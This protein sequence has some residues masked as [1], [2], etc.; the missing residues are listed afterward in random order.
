MVENEKR[1]VQRK[2]QR[3][4]LELSEIYAI[5]DE[6]MIAHIGFNDPDTN[7]PVVIPMLYTRDHD[8][9]LLHASTGGRF[10][11]ALKS[12]IPICA[13]ITL[14]DGLVVA[15]SAFNSSM[16]YRSVMAF[17]IPAV[18]EEDAKYDAL[19]KVSDGLV[20]GLWEHGREITSK[21]I[22]QTMV[23]ELKLDQV[24]AK[25]RAAGALDD[26]DAALPI[27]AGVIP[28]KTIKG[29]PIT[30]ENASHVQIP[31]YVKNLIDNA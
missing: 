10:G 15:R 29:A 6:G 4:V 3:E 5:L 26:D 19:V 30:N 28:I 20:P 27:W 21:E 25:K 24:S 16:N 12:G 2:P 31:E 7:E 9:I 23:L 18:L 14:V 22:A 1:H 11:L 8:R 13:T 17:G